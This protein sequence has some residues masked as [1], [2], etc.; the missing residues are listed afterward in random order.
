MKRRRKT[1]RKKSHGLSGHTRRRSHKR[2]LFDGMLSGQNLKHSAI[3]TGL[4]ALGG[5]GSSVGF[6]LIQGVTK[7]NV[8]G[9]IL[10]GALI[11]FIAS[12]LGAPKIGIGF[13]GGTTALALAGG[14]H[15]EGNAEFADDDSLSEIYQT[16]SGEFVKMLNDGSMEYLNDDEVSYL[17]EDVYPGYSTMNAFQG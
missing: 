9:N 6:K 3:N 15:D 10:G 2:G 4:G 16:E 5:A 11:G 12:S 13:V 8:F 17:S 14:L 1:H 7:G